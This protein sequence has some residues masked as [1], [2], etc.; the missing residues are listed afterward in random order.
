MATRETIPHFITHKQGS[1]FI[2]S[3]LAAVGSNTTALACRSTLK[4]DGGGG[5]L[6]FIVNCSCYHATHIHSR[7]ASV[8]ALTDVL[9]CQSVS[10]IK[11]QSSPWAALLSSLFV[12]LSSTKQRLPQHS[13]QLN[14]LRLP[15]EVRL[16]LSPPPPVTL[17]KYAAV[18]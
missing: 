8:W 13:L 12:P 10:P 15:G 7:S 6:Y 1:L 18:F 9:M 11:P 2:L 14:N 5:G 17:M 3:S 16:L 4:A